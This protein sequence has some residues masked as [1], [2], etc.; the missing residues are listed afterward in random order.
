MIYLDKE[1]GYDIGNRKRQMGVSWT[2]ETSHL[3]ATNLTGDVKK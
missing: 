1:T 3:V 2:K